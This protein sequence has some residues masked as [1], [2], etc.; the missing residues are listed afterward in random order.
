MRQKCLS[1]LK[2]RSHPAG[3][4][5]FEQS[6]R[7]R[8]I[9]LLTDVRK[10]RSGRPSAIR[11]RILDAVA[12]PIGSGVMANDSDVLLA[13]ITAFAA[14]LATSLCLRWSERRS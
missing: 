12:E 1:L 6:M 2:Q 10:K 13:A 5:L 9:A 4:L 3:G 14:N 7:L 11:L 8:D